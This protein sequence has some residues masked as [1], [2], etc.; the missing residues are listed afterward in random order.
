MNDRL[1]L[2]ARD[3]HVSMLSMDRYDAGEFDDDQRRC[4]EGHVERC[5]LCR[6]RLAS[7]GTVALLPPGQPRHETG[8]VTLGYLAT[9]AGAALAACL[10]ATLG[11]TLW[12]TPQ[13]AQQTDP[14]A[15][16]V[17]SAYT[18][19]AQEYSDMERPDLAVTRRGEQLVL[20]AAAGGVAVV[21]V[22]DS[23]DGAGTGGEAVEQIVEVVGVSTVE[24]EALEVVYPRRA[25]GLRVLA[26]ACTQ[27]LDYA[28]GDALAPDEDC[29]V[30]EL[31]ALPVDER[32]S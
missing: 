15:L 4:L 13:V 20:R 11:A 18:S 8:S 16:G 21:V 30:R 27:P 31:H 12:P 28:V 3:G 29:T 24:G 26:L 9:T 23:E 10:V 14:E 5:G 32:D 7:L 22:G 2:F 1:D 17:S 19:V 6:E 25:A